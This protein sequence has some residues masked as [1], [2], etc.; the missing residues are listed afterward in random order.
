MNTRLGSEWGGGRGGSILPHFISIECLQNPWE[1]LGARYKCGRTPGL[2]VAKIEPPV[3]DEVQQHTFLSLDAAIY[4]KLWFTLKK[5][6]VLL[7]FRNNL[8]RCFENWKKFA[9]F[10]L[11]NVWENLN[12]GNITLFTANFEWRKVFLG[13][14][15]LTRYKLCYPRR[16]NFVEIAF[17]YIKEKSKISVCRCCLEK[18]TFMQQL[19]HRW[20]MYSL[21]KRECSMKKKENQKSSMIF[22]FSYGTNVVNNTRVTEKTAILTRTHEWKF[23]SCLNSMKTFLKQAHS[24]YLAPSQR[25]Q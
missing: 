15:C 2:D 4:P 10:I 17:K 12:I 8:E 23:H 21:V 16:Q 24:D 5:N 6:R 14:K 25:V 3:I 18:N 11:I 20:L 9:N 13:I 7:I 22:V 19:P 1:R